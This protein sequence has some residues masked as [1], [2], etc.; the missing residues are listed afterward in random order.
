MTYS[1]VTKEYEQLT[2]FG[3]DAKWTSDG[4]RLL[5][6]TVREL[7]IVDRESKERTKLYTHP[8]AISPYSLSNL[9]DRSLFF[10]TSEPEADIW[11][12]TLE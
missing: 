6:Q 11:V 7:W 8:T 10:A 12:A 9:A 2:D 4:R 3:R 1:F 5:F